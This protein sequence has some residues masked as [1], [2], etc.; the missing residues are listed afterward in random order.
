M[1]QQPTSR[2]PGKRR[3][4]VQIW[5]P[6]TK[7][8]DRDLNAL[9][10][11]RDRFL[12]ELFRREIEALAQEVTFRNCDA[13]RARMQQQK[14]P[15]RVKQTLELDEDVIV[16]IDAVLEERNIPRDSFINRV[17]FFL[18]AKEPILKHLDI[19]YEREATASAKPLSDALGYLYNPFFHIREANDQ[20]FYTLA[21]FFEG[22]FGPKG[23]NLFSLNTAISDDD[24]A[25]FNIDSDA[26]LAEL[27]M[28][29]NAGATHV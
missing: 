28:L 6:L 7:A 1:E 8:V 11:K 13:V 21:C 10:I 16:R 22:A 29:S 19:A 14:I 18:V 5:K 26:L 3:I 23:P 25:F 27:G 17:L 2:K 4:M 9:N 24:W 15:E 20:R 12:N